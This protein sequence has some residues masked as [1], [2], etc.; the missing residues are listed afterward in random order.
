MMAILPH[1][2][3]QKVD[4]QHVGSVLKIATKLLDLKSFPFH[5]YYLQQVRKSCSLPGIFTFK[6]PTQILGNKI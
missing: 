3:I 5:L 6:N 1:N 2:M 4:F